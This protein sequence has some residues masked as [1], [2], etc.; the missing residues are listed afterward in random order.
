MREYCETIM[1]HTLYYKIF[2]KFYLFRVQNS[3]LQ[4]LKLL[5]GPFHQS[6]DKDLKHNTQSRISE[7]P[8]YILQK[9]NK[10]KLDLASFSFHDM[11][12]F[13]PNIK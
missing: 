7:R 12:E 13:I 8:P 2:A 5:F 6:S 1:L 10:T 4:Q 11:I 9:L 3:S